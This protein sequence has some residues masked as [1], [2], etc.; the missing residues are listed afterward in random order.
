MQKTRDLIASRLRYIAFNIIL[1]IP[2]VEMS[3]IIY[4]PGA[5]GS[6]MVRSETLKK[7]LNGEESISHSLSASNFSLQPG[8]GQ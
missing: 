7:L 5:V 6:Q 4:S 1:M 8:Q 2:A 3:Q